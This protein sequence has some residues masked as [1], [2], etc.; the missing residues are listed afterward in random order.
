LRQYKVTMA[1]S[2]PAKKLISSFK[3]TTSG[4]S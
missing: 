2:S 4:K 1:R 3:K